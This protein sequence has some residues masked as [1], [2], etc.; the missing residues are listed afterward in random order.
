MGVG[1]G[2][3]VGGRCPSFEW[4]NKFVRFYF[5]NIYIF[6]DWYS[7]LGLN[8]DFFYADS[9]N[10]FYTEPWCFFLYLDADGHVLKQ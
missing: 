5:G 6:E 7:V 8:T 10:R 2:V 1:F 3:G 9:K 4:P